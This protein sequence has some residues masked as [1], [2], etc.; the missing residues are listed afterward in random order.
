MG[1]KKW[2]RVHNNKR[3]TPLPSMRKRLRS[4]LS[5]SSPNRASESGRLHFLPSPPLPP[6]PP[7][8]PRF[9]LLLSA[10]SVGHA[11]S[12]PLWRRSLMPFVLTT[13]S[14][15]TERYG[16]LPRYY[17]S[18]PQKNSEKADGS[19]PMQLR[20]NIRSACDDN[21]ATTWISQT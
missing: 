3:T 7:P 10:N 18:I 12:R 11:L 20:S 17:E 9:P 1:P 16:S 6:P 19:E 2:L 14:T 15:R 21:G 4:A 5:L 13:V 8:L